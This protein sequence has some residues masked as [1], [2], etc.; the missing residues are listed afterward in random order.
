MNVLLLPRTETAAAVA[1]L[2]TRWSAAGLLRPFCVSDAEE[3]SLSTQRVRAGAAERMPLSRAL[4]DAP[5][6]PEAVEFVAF[7]PLGAEEEADA[8]FADAVR[9]FLERAARHV[10]DAQTDRRVLTCVLAVAPETQDKRLPPALY[11]SGWANLLV[12]PEDRASPGKVN[13]LEEG[14][15]RFLRHAAHAAATIGALWAT[16]EPNLPDLPARLR[17]EPAGTLQVP[18]RVVRCYSRVVELGYIVDHIAAATFECRGSWPRPGKSFEHA[19]DPEELLASVARVYMERHRDTLVRRSFSPIHDVPQPLPDLFTALVRLAEQIV[20]YVRRLPS[21]LLEEAIATVHEKAADYIEAL[22]R[23]TGRIAV[24]RWR[25]A[26]D[27]GAELAALDEALAKEPLVIEDGAVERTWTELRK[28]TLGLV[29]GSPLPDGIRQQA[30]AA[31]DRT[32]VVC[33]PAL[34][35][36]DPAAVVAAEEPEEDPGAGGEDEE[37]APEPFLELIRARVEAA[38]EEAVARVTALERPA[39]P[40]QPEEEEEES[41]AK[42]RR[43]GG[44]WL[45]RVGRRIFLALLVA[46]VAIAAATTFLSVLPAIAVSAAVLAGLFLA[47]GFAARDA[48]RHPPIP[49]DEEAAAELRELNRILELAQA[50]GD[51]ERLGRRL[52]EPRHLD[53]DPRRAGPPPVGARAIRRGGDRRDRRR[54]DPSRRLPSRGRRSRPRA[55]RGARRRCPRESLSARLALER[56]P[57][58]AR[59]GPRRPVAAG[60]RRGSARR[61]HRHRRGGGRRNAARGAAR[62]GAAGARPQPRRQPDRHRPPRLDQRRPAGNARA[63]GAPGLGRRPPARPHGDLDRAACRRRRGCREPRAA[64]GRAWRPQLQ[65]RSRRRGSGACRRRRGRRLADGRDPARGA[66]RSRSPRRSCPRAPAW[67]CCASSRASARRS[68]WRPRGLAPVPAW[69]RSS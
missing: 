67:R 64:G 28:I 13:R 19:Q 65:R 56:L 63:G 38:R 27:D 66:P 37:P 59:A 52:R 49:D 18:V 46:V 1:E 39:S 44:S 47:V 32:K 33:D 31:G 26:A 15:D 53:R 61:C 5:G 40:E 2:L 24:R 35:A 11:R 8:G 3:A 54:G 17:E 16:P 29:D 21:R 22:S 6:E 4:A 9:G 34:I 69:S 10:F 48:L 12:A 41:K 43:R 23:S 20:A 57:R 55:A 42:R 62:R 14:G 7:Y 51:A 68:R 45:R 36:H 25:E 50:R 60:G 30:R 58:R